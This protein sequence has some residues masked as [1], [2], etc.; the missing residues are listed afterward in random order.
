MSE[1][2]LFDRNFIAAKLARLP[3]P[4]DDFVTALI[5]SDLAERI[6]AV[7]RTFEKALL[8][9][10]LPHQGTA[11]LKTPA[12][13]ITFTRFVTLDGKDR[14]GELA[15]LP[16]DF[17]LIVSLHDLA[18]TNDVPGFLQT[19]RNRL[20]PDGLLLAAFVG[21]Y[22]LTE[23]RQAWL[24]ADSERF[25]GAALRIVPMVELADASALLQAG[26]FGLPIADLET[27]TIRYA[28]PLALMRDIRTLGGS[29]P[30]RGST[31][32]LITP[33]HLA[34]AISTYSSQFS[35]PD[36]RIR[37]TL[38]IVWLSAW[39]PHESQQKPL[40]PGSADISLA[41]VLKDKS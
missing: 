8:I 12:Q 32:G 2:D 7:T 25:G 31:P 11:T 39:K 35:D 27:H 18:I 16:D 40:K 4:Q 22:S 28:D 38:E 10:P 20:R 21:G 13:D 6:D 9:T 14:A 5:W 34:R 30:L 23:L 15:E 37:A 24:E 17:D 19:L 26:R 29:N 1:T 36:G 3:V 33:N 41:K